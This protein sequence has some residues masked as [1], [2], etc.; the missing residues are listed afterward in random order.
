MNDGQVITM[1]DEAAKVGKTFDTGPRHPQQL[2]VT[3]GVAALGTK[4]MKV[5]H[6]TKYNDDYKDAVATGRCAIYCMD[7][8]GVTMAIAVIYGWAGAKKGSPEAART[9]DLLAIIQMQ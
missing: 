9:D 4:D 2:K 5:H 8:N 6:I 7:V 3:A 1:K